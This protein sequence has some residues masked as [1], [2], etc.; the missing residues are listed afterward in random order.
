MPRATDASGFVYLNVIGPRK[1]KLALSSRDA[2]FGPLSAQRMG[3]SQLLHTAYQAFDGLTAPAMP[4]S[5]RQAFRLGSA[6]AYR[7]TP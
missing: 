4:R 5:L 6:S 2:E 1:I 3:Y 7:Q